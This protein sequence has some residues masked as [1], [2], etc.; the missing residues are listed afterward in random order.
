MISINEVAD[1]H[2]RQP[3]VHIAEVAKVKDGKGGI[4]G[5]H[6]VHLLCLE[7]FLCHLIFNSNSHLFFV[8][9]F[10]VEHCEGPPCKSVCI[11]D[12]IGHIYCQRHKG[13]RECVLGWAWR[14]G[15]LTRSDRLKA[16]KTIHLFHLV[17]VAWGQPASARLR[18]HSRPEARKGLQVLT[19]WS[20][21]YHD[22]DKVWWL[23]WP[24]RHDIMMV[25]VVMAWSSRYYD[26]GKGWWF[27]RPDRHEMKSCD[28]S[29]KAPAATDICDCNVDGFKRSKLPER[30]TYFFSIL[31]DFQT[32]PTFR[33]SETWSS[34]S[35]KERQ[36]CLNNLVK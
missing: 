29:K 27:R 11:P 16:K 10:I 32:L 34:W 21:R 24:G 30:K 26:G 15:K 5:K 33:V 18:D 23:L 13:P 4:S 19:T 25:M 7:R 14:L 28:E 22:G 35:G 1:D 6:S 31:I 36:S 2:S 12:M 20:S 17:F 8:K 9:T 3:W